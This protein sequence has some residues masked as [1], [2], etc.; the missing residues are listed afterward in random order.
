MFSGPLGASFGPLSVFI[1][2]TLDPAEHA[3]L[4]RNARTLKH[5]PAAVAPPNGYVVLHQPVTTDGKGEGGS[6]DDDS[7]KAELVSQGNEN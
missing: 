1:A 3:T 5:T 7:N 4:V 2:P 6:D